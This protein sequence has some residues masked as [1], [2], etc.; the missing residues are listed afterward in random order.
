MTGEWWWFEN[1]RGFED[2]DMLDV[3]KKRWGCWRFRR[4]LQLLLPLCITRYIYIPP[5]RL[6][7][8]PPYVMLII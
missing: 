7:C 3:G 4:L 6:L 1:L 5:I 2:G 8:L